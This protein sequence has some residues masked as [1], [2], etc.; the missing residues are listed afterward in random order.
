R[1]AILRQLRPGQRDKCAAIMCSFAS[2]AD[3]G[4][5]RAWTWACARLR[6]QLLE[7]R[8]WFAFRKGFANQAAKAKPR[9][10]RD[11][12]QGIGLHRRPGNAAAQP[13]R[14]ARNHGP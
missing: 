4:R 3:G 10:A 5:R 2:G 6:C 1:T 7:G 14:E 12:E 11:L 13:W 9:L 8:T